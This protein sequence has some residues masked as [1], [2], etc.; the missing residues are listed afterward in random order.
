MEPTSNL[1]IRHLLLHLRPL[2]RRLRL[3]VQHQSERAARL[4]RPDVTHLC[5]SDDQ[6]NCLLEDID[7]LSLMQPPHDGSL[8]AIHHA[9]NIEEQ[10]QNALLQA[11][12]QQLGINLPLTLL[13]QEV[14]LD[15]W[16]QQVLLLCAMPELQRAF[17]QIYGY[18]LDDMNRRYASVEL[19][20][21]L[22][23]SSLADQMSARMAFAS[24]SRLRRYGLITTREKAPTE[25]RQEFALAP[26]VFDVLTGRVNYVAN[27]Y[28]DPA[29]VP[30]VEMT[31]LP[32]RVDQK[33][34]QQIC[35]SVNQAQLSIANIWGTKRCS[36]DDMAMAIA[37]VSNKPL[38][39]VKLT[40]PGNADLYGTQVDELKEALATAHTLD[41][42]LWIDLADV[43][44]QGHPQLSD[45]L[46]CTIIASSVA[47]I[48]T[49]HHPWR[50]TRLLQHQNYLELPLQAPD[51]QERKIL[52]AQVVPELE[53]NEVEDIAA[54]LRLG[55]PEMRAAARMA[56]A[57]ARLRSNGTVSTVAEQ[58]TQACYIVSSRHATR[59]AQRVTPKRGPKDLILQPELHQQ[60]MELTRFCKGWHKV[61]EEWQFGR[62][63]SG[64]G[65]MK[66][67]FVGDSGTGK[68]LAAEVIAGQLG[69]PMLKV[70]LARV[71]SKWVGETEKNLEMVFEE[72]EES[73]AVLFFDEADS[74]FGKR[75]EVQR[76]SDRYANL[77]VGY[78]LQR[79]EDY[80]GLVILASNLKDQIDSAMLRRF[81]AIIHFTRPGEGERRQLWKMAFPDAAPLG[82]DT[83][84]A[85]LQRLD[86]TGASIINAA[87]NAALLATERGSEQI[88]M[89]HIVQAVARQYQ[90]EARLLSPSDLGEHAV[91]L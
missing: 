67:L 64:G 36:P 53:A 70:D 35:R 13:Q 60:I 66:S 44:I 19:L 8:P 3:A 55:L 14:A 18:I 4:A 81:Q 42:I 61:D 65:G 25:L 11:E 73:N 30:V 23:P 77:E 21:L 17:E 31:H 76:G 24:D 41:A 47:V 86:M 37:A 16:E 68:T 88:T 69:L 27:M 38:R 32:A 48:I 87:R 74:L 59:Y 28:H 80:W 75:G 78:L 6:V 91:L 71:V 90:R 83:D 50:T 40:L 49:A 34:F 85:T 58:L 15:N 2:Q 7:Q 20:T 29:N 72:A 43:A 10:E 9:L 33:I 22:A 12:A 82:D 52:W 84:I 46:A 56:R 63:Q 1:V 45:K 79:L 57:Q 39:R 26:G 89:Q 54:R 51:Y 62:L 5:V